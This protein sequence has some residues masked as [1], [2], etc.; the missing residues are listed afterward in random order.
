MVSYCRLSI[1]Q[2]GSLPTMLMF[3]SSGCI[4]K[5]TEQD[6]RDSRCSRCGSRS[7][8]DHRRSTLRQSG[9]G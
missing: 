7:D 1:T 5:C 3:W 4:R 2:G 9:L 8:P 6:S